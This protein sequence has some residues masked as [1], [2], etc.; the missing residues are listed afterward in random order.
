MKISPI[1]L[2]AVLAAGSLSLAFADPAADLQAAVA[3]GATPLVAV[4]EAVAANPAAAAEIV[5]AAIEANAATEPELIVSI[6]EAAMKGLPPEQ[7]QAFA[8]QMAQAY[9]DLEQPILALVEALKNGNA[10]LSAGEPPITDPEGQIFLASTPAGLGGSQK[11]Q[12]EQDAQ[13]DDDQEG[14]DQ[15]GDAQGEG[16]DGDGDGNPGGGPITK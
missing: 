13:D 9:P 5:A 14:G 10:I 1:A 6:I 11:A 4:E 7:R 8:E 12:L 2:A 16:E 15:D 3:A